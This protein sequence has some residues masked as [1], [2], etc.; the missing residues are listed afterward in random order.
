[1]LATLPLLIMHSGWQ[2]QKLL[3]V[4]A[5]LCQA[6][7]IV[8]LSIFIL[9]T[10]MR[11]L[12]W[13]PCYIKKKIKLNNCWRRER[14]KRSTRR[15]RKGEVPFWRQFCWDDSN[16]GFGSFGSETC[17]LSRG[18]CIMKTARCLQPGT[19]G[20]CGF[21]TLGRGQKERDFWKWHHQG[22]SSFIAMH[23][24]SSAYYEVIDISMVFRIS[25]WLNVM[26]SKTIALTSVITLQP[27]NQ[28]F[29]MVLRFELLGIWKKKSKKV[30]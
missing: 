8:L 19:T 9:K 28:N 20:H 14:R 10:F 30:S 11:Y 5:A 16:W 2:L 7:S 6:L 22:T 3:R 29:F 12:L 4:C 13:V 21:P 24:G 23:T 1:M 25:Y 15:G 27:W 18:T 17:A 26:V